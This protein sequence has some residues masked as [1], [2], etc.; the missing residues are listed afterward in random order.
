M[1]LSYLPVT[2]DDD[3]TPWDCRSVGVVFCGSMGQQ[4]YASPMEC[5]GMNL[6]MIHPSSLLLKLNTSHQSH[7]LKHVPPTSLCSQRP[8][9]TTRSPPKTLEIAT[10][11]MK[12]HVKYLNAAANEDKVFGGALKFFWPRSGKQP[13]RITFHQY[14]VRTSTHRAAVT[15]PSEPHAK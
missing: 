2:V 4:S 6:N 13:S 14:E 7:Q 11:I 9:L 15:S 5:L 3:D 10:P 8:V 1:G 12:K